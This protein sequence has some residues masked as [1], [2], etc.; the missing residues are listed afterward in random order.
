MLMAAY[1]GLMLLTEMANEYAISRS[2]TMP[3]GTFSGSAH[4]FN[5]L[6]RRAS[7]RRRSRDSRHDR[8]RTTAVS[9]NRRQL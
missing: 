7:A 9:G 2:K 5:E 8:P 3:P 6:K 4:A 1:E